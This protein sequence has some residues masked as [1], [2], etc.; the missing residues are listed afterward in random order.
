MLHEQTVDEREN[1]EFD[2]RLVSEQAVDAHDAEDADYRD[3]GK[4][5]DEYQRQ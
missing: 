4:N 5:G 1:G 3:G 2:E